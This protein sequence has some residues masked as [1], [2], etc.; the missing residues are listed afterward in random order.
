[1][2][3]NLFDSTSRQWNDDDQAATAPGVRKIV[4]P[5]CLFMCISSRR[6]DLMLPH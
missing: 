6:V 1:M 2:K 4:E 3:K 5:R